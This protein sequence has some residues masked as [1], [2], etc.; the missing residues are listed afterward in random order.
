MH[1][2]KDKTPQKAELNG[3][4]ISPPPHGHSHVV[5][6]FFFFPGER[7]FC[8]FKGMTN[9]IYKQEEKKKRH[10]CPYQKLTAP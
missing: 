4:V 2:T 5:G 1:K 7:F 6:S 8:L 3:Q 10:L 9:A